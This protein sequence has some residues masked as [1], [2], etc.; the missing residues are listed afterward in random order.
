[1][2][3]VT[4]INVPRSSRLC[5]ANSST[6]KLHARSQQSRNY[7][8][9]LLS[10]TLKKYHVGVMVLQCLSARVCYTTKR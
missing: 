9:L 6:R 3:E 2:S 1:M 8:S 10:D 4:E 5:T 7:L